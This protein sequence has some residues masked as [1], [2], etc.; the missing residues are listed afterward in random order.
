MIN[1]EALRL[2][3][4]Y[5]TRT[6]TLDNAMDEIQSTLGS[7]FD[8]DEWMDVMQCIICDPLCFAAVEKEFME[9]LAGQTNENE[10]MPSA[11]GMYLAYYID[12][13]LSC[14]GP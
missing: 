8:H 1:K 14:T 11:S 3:S 7:N 2:L 9:K 12:I 6:I 10:G 4:Q 5:A 13:F